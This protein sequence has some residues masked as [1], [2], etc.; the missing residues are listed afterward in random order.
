MNADPTGEASATV[1]AGAAPEII[2]RPRE[3]RPQIA[4]TLCRCRHLTP[5][6]AVPHGIVE[7]VAQL[8]TRRN[9][10]YRREA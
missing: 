5:S 4:P 9:F 10:D 2:P 6:G 8:A 3:S 1:V 7:D